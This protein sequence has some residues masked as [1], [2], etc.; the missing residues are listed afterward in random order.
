[1]R[2][3]AT[4]RKNEPERVGTRLQVCPA[5]HALRE[6]GYELPFPCTGERTC[7]NPEMII[8]KMPLKE[9]IKYAELM[10]DYANRVQF[11][12]KQRRLASFETKENDS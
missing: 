8:E 2:L 11:L 5:C 7:P 9:A 3:L 12:V 10:G 6:L 1:M 4:S